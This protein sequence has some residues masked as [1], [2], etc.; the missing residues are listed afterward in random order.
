[1]GN[2]MPCQLARP[3]HEVQQ[4]VHV[5][6]LDA[7]LPQCVLRGKDAPKMKRLHSGCPTQREQV[8]GTDGLDAPIGA[9]LVVQP[10][11]DVAA[12]A[13]DDQQCDAVS[14]ARLLRSACIGGIDDL[15]DRIRELSES[16][17]LTGEP[18]VLELV[19]RVD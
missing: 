18:T 9:L 5:V 12:H 6:Q 11:G 19:Q 2:Q 3:G 8:R 1:M 16:L 17:E 10:Q 7:P 15:V 14:K 4:P 13:A